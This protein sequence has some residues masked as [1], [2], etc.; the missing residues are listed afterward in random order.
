MHLHRDV[1]IWPDISSFVAKNVTINPFE[2]ANSTIVE[3]FLVQ[4]VLHG[5]PRER[6]FEDWCAEKL[7]TGVT[8]NVGS[9]Y[10]VAC[11]H[12]KVRNDG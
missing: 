11:R 1:L 2:C 9:T 8:A 7:A 3:R 10:E 6:L 4:I 5:L 12:E